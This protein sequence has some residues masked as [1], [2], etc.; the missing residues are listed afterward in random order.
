MGTGL[1]LGTQAAW[2]SVNVGVGGGGDR[3]HSPQSLGHCQRRL[4]MVDGAFIFE[5]QTQQ[6]HMFLINKNELNGPDTG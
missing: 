2:G 4:P 5:P 3:P 6:F 1:C